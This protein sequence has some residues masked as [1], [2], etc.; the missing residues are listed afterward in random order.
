LAVASGSEDVVELLLN[1]GASMNI[2]NKYGETPLHCCAR[3]LPI[4][5]ILV[6]A[7]SFK[8]KQSQFY[9][10]ITEIKIEFFYI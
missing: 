5:S 4:F 8:K 2:K 9:Y 10:K 3:S 6:V 7:S 1:S